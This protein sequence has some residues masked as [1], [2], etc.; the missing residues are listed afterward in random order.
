MKLHLTANL[1]KAE[2]VHE[3]QDDNGVIRHPS[4]VLENSWGPSFIFEIIESEQGYEIHGVVE[5]SA[6]AESGV[7]H[8]NLMANSAAD[9]AKVIRPVI[10][11][12]FQAAAYGITDGESINPLS[13]HKEELMKEWRDARSKIIGD[14]SHL[15]KSP[16]TQLLRG[17]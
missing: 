14:A 5:N 12:E 9:V 6:V 11:S 7:A 3:I 8:Y 16:R 2:F 1:K 15:M 17:Q 13:L 10:D 4:I